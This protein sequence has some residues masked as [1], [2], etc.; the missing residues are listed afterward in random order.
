MR[1]PK[2]GGAELVPQVRDLP[3]TVNGEERAVPAVTGDFCPLC[4]EAVLTGTE[5][6]RVSAAI[7]AVAPG[8]P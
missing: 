3:F 8:A 7:M 1:C 4:G 2:C 5:A 6:A